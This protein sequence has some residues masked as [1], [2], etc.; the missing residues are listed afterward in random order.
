MTPE[1]IQTTV[2]WTN[3]GRLWRVTLTWDVIEDRW[4][5]VGLAIAAGAPDTPLHAVD[6]R[7]LTLGRL[8]AESRPKLLEEVARRREVLK[9]SHSAAIESYLLRKLQ[10]ASQ[11]KASPGR[12]PVHSLGHYAEVAKAYAEAYAAGDYPT[13]AV[14]E[15]FH[16]SR[17]AA[18]K[19]IA[20]CRALGFLGPTEKRKAGGLP[21]VS[22]ERLAEEVEL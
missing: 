17:S 14:A 11:P 6:L 4:E 2:G 3:E 18:G 13:R 5:C 16:M 15:H 9:D 1:P 20:R 10:S 19:Q 8:V 7:A 12:P 22:D 21:P